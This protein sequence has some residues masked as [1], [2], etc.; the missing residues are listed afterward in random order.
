MLSCY[1]GKKIGKKEKWT[2]KGTDKQYVA[3]SL[4]YDTK[5]LEKMKNGQIKGLISNMW[6]IL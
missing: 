6:L 5:H 3:D 1:D 4:I 2:N